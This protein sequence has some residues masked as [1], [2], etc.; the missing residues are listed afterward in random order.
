MK[1]QDLKVSI[2]F[3]SSMKSKNRFGRKILMQ[4][5]F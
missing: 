3:I 5:K 1:R 4:I 2:P